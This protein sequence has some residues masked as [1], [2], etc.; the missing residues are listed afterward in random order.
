MDL[1][2]YKDET[3]GVQLFESETLTFDKIQSLNSVYYRKIGSVFMP[4]GLIIQADPFLF[5]RNNTLYLFYEVL[6][7]GDKGCIMMVQTN[8]LKSWSEPVLVLKEP[9]H[10]SFPFVFEY[11]GEV[12][13]IPESQE[14]NEI[15]LYKAN[16]N[17]TS[18]SYVKN[19]TVNK[20]L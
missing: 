15:R 8:D 12:Y 14:C 19:R 18:F 11:N 1:I 16:M 17:I 20:F 9:W 5:I 7:C 6:R 4:K 10:L 13:M 3:F 2:S